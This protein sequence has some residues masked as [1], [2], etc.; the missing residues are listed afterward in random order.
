MK[1]I[2]KK[3]FH[4][5]EILET[6]ETGLVLNGA[7]VKS[8]RSGRMS[9]EGAFVRIIG[10]EIY[11][12]NAQIFPYA[13]ARPENYDPKRSRKLLMHKREI[14]SLKSKLSADRLTLLPLECYNSQSF[15]KLKIGLARGRKQY[16]KREKLKKKAV[17]R[18][19]ERAL[20]SKP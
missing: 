17:V 20:K 5:F 16:E 1:I 10:S 18:D 3:A 4:D 15:L 12:V 11:L 19:I 9:L 6:Y 8:V 7:E 14:T 2:N 13:Y